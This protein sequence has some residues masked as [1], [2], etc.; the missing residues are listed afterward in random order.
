MEMEEDEV[1]DAAFE[2]IIKNKNY[3]I[4]SSDISE[5]KGMLDNSMSNTFWTKFDNNFY[6]IKDGIL[7]QAPIKSDDTV[8]IDNRKDATLVSSSILEQINKE[9]CSSFKL[10]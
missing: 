5:L 4:L 9:F 7:L 10:H 1:Q 8:D 3:K 2:T 6:R